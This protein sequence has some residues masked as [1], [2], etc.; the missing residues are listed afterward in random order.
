MY[1]APEVLEITNEWLVSIWGKA[2]PMIGFTVNRGDGWLKRMMREVFKLKIR[3]PLVHYS[4]YEDVSTTLA[5]GSPKFDPNV[6]QA[7]AR[8]RVRYGH[9]F[10]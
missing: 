2:W 1:C 6:Q 7:C 8:A 3:K 5:M 9:L 4:S 10:W